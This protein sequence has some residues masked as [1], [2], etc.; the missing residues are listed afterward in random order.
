MQTNLAASNPKL[1]IVYTF[2]GTTTLTQQLEQQVPA[3]VIASADQVSIQK[4]LTAKLIDTPSV[5]ARN[6]LQ[7]AVAKGNPKG[8]TKLADLA[9]PGVKVALLDAGTPAGRDVTRVFD[10][11]ILT[12]T[13]VAKPLDAKAALTSVTTGKADATVL[14]VT[15]VAAA[16]D[17][18][19]GVPITDSQNLV[20]SYRIAVVKAAKNR[21][22]AKEFVNYVVNGPGQKVANAHGFLGP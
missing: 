11:Q 19:T 21:E 1:S 18:V 4:L 2:A 13:P 16:R 8:I 15:D 5:F 14:Y 20:S 22:A 10:K 12:V 7:I 9:R 17:T 3:D 6:K